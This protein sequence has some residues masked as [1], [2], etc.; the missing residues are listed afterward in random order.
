M[1]EVHRLEQQ[2]IA[3]QQ[4]AQRQE[5]EQQLAQADAARESAASQQAAAGTEANSMR[6]Q[7]A[8]QPVDPVARS[9][10]QLR[11]MDSVETIQL[12]KVRLNRG[13]VAPPNDQQIEQATEA[14]RGM[15]ELHTEVW[16]GLDRG[17]RLEVLREVEGRM[18]VIQRRPPVEVGAE[19]MKEGMFGGY[20]PQDNAI[21][22]SE[23]H[24][25]SN[26]VR[27]VVDTMVH[28]GRHAYQ[29]YAVDHPGFHSNQAEVDGWRYNI[30]HYLPAEVVGQ[31]RYMQQPIE[32]DAFA[33]GNEISRNV[34]GG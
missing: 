32:A 30:D 33:Y 4:E 16:Q 23:E 14:L 31:R 13:D 10:A 21:R 8:D 34:M 17:Q 1:S 28:E 29:Q 12:E 18:A 7:V 15:D 22:V 20:S 26:D 19:H 25:H 2:E 9:E 11:Q 3:R 6:A 24:L 27:E 5:L